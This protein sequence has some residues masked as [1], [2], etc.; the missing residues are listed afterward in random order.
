M[1]GKRREENGRRGWMREI[2]ENS[3]VENLK[4][5]REGKNNLFKVLRHLILE[6]KE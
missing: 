1:A 3:K 4:K 6:A 5:T 2:V